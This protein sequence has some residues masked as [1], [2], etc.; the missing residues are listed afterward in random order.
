[1]SCNQ[2]YIY[3]ADF[4]GNYIKKN[5]SNSKTSVIQAAKTAPGHGLSGLKPDELHL[6]LNA[7]MLLPVA[8]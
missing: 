7:N 1:M 4:I 2:S 3:W 6:E 5:S 8:S